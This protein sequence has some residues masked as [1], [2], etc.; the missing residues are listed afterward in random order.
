[1]K[2][3]PTN[4]E[5]EPI[6]VLH[7]FPGGWSSR[8]GRT[9]SPV[10]KVIKSVYHSPRLISL[11]HACAASGLLGNAARKQRLSTDAL[12]DA[13][14]KTWNSDTELFLAAAAE[15][16][17]TQSAISAHVVNLPSAMIGWSGNDPVRFSQRR[18][19]VSV[20]GDVAQTVAILAR[21]V[22][23]LFIRDRHPEMVW[24]NLFHRIFAVDED[25]NPAPVL[26]AKPWSDFL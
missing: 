19:G 2:Q 9:K 24:E 17:V 21:C 6:D 14:K 26:E 4:C 22:G 12:R 1:M 13:A 25:I 3:K 15:I 23:N 11:P 20:V 5:S 16:G 8:G 10:E 18:S 7:C